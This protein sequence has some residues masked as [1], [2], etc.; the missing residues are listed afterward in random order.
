MPTAAS[1]QAARLLQQQPWPM[2]ARRRPGVRQRQAWQ[3]RWLTG[4]GVTAGRRA[5]GWGLR[6]L[7]SIAATGL[8]AA[9]GAVPTAVAAAAA[10]PTVVA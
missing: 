7:T 4:R 10:V 3:R 2:P 9:A 1:M 8:I 6:V 5:R